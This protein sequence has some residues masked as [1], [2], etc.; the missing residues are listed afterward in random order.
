M[1]NSAA[2][3][4]VLE[5]SIPTAPPADRV[6]SPRTRPQQARAQATVEA[7]TKATISIINEVGT[8]A[9]TT[10]RIA[11]TAGVSIGTLYRYFPDKKSILFKVYGDVLLELEA[12]LDLLTDPNQAPPTWKEYRPL[13]Q[14]G[15]R[16][17]EAPH[18]AV[19]SGRANMMYVE[20]ED[21]DLDHCRRQAR[22]L[23]RMLAHYGSSWPLELIE[24]LTLFCIYLSDGAWHL[25]RVTNAYDPLVDQWR[26]TGLAGVLELAFD[27]DQRHLQPAFAAP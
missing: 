4:S 11:D 5:P 24:R 1:M 7:I 22:K 21:L 27:D 20:F 26:F 16:R 6:G 19:L 13:L 12:A 15:I 14:T 3:S 18:R 17:Y 23:A 25:H 2:L 9:L 8:A 10:A